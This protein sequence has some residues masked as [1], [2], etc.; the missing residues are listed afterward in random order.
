MN[1]FKNPTTILAIGCLL[2]LIGVQFGLD[3]DLEW[4]DITLRLICGLLVTV[5]ILNNP[6][7][8]GIS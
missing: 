5:G 1:R 8:P 3:I 4:L 7:T 2:G 6:T